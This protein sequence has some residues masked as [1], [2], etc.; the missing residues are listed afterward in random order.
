MPTDKITAAVGKGFDKIRQKLGPAGNFSL[1][2]AAIAGGF[3]SVLSITGGWLP[4]YTKDRQTGRVYMQ[5]QI[6]DRSGLKAAIADADTLYFAVAGNVF[7]IQQ[8]LT[9]PPLGEPQLWK[10]YGYSTVGEWSE[11]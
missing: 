6:V 8:D 9:E 4:V 7:T 11:T 3:A 1:L 5:V 10:L 2:R